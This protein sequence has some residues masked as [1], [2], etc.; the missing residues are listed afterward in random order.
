[1]D[2][3]PIIRVLAFYGAIMSMQTNVWA[4]F[5]AIGK[6]KLLT[7]FGAVNLIVLIPLLLVLTSEAGPLGA[8]CAFLI[9]ISISTPIVLLTLMRQLNLKR[10]AFAAKVWRPILAAALMY[11]SIGGLK[12]WLHPNPYF[13]LL[14][15]VLSGA[16]FYIVSILILWN[17]Q[18]RPAG[19]EAY[20]LGRLKLGWANRA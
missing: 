11:F 10:A 20:L 2:A 1:M 16:A 15:C 7:L 5:M 8:S 13:A 6:P 9:S 3:V 17:L 14:V 4:V 18:S 19:S 12:H